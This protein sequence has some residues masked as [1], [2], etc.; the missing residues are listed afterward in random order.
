MPEILEKWK[1]AS[2]LERWDSERGTFH[3]YKKA[4]RRWWAPCEKY[5][6]LWQA[7]LA[8]SPIPS[9]PFSLGNNSYYPDSEC[10]GT[11]LTYFLLL[12]IPW[13]R[14]WLLDTFGAYE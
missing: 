9:L 6:Q 13:S 10:Q 8:A 7:P 5:A 2:I 3:K 12:Q 11:Q 1:M 4:I 14:E